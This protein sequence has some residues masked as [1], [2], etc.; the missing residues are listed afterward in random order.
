MSSIARICSQVLVGMSKEPGRETSTDTVSP[1]T[2]IASVWSSGSRIVICCWTWT[3]SAMPTFYRTTKPHLQAACA[4]LPNRDFAM[5]GGVRGSRL[6]SGA[7]QVYRTTKSS[8]PRMAAPSSFCR[9]SGEPY[10]WLMPRLLSRVL[11]TTS[12]T[13]RIAIGSQGVWARRGRER[14]GPSTSPRYARSNCGPDA[15]PRPHA[16]PTERREPPQTGSS[17]PRRLSCEAVMLRRASNAP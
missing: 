1:M 17:L 2:T 14:C 15:T 9:P 11:P 12:A 3:P 4:A 16:D 7:L 10:G 8:A 5:G 6:G 13:Y